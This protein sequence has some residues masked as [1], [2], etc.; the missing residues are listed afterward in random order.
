MGVFTNILRIAISAFFISTFATACSNG[1]CKLLDECSSDGDCEAG[2][3]CFSCAMEFSGSR[4]VRSTATD[5]FKLLNNSLPYNKYAYLTTHNAFA[6]D[7][8]P[9]HAGVPRITFNN[10]EDTITQQLNNGVRALMLDTYDFEDDIWLC[11]SAE[12]KCHHITAFEPA[13]D[14]LKEIEAFLAANPSEIVTLILEDYVKTP[15]GLTNVFTAAG[16]MKYWFPVS[17]MPRNG[18]DWPLVSDMVAN[19]QRLVVFT[20]RKSK[21][22][23]EGIAYQWDYMVENQYGQGGMKEGECPNRGESSPLN[24]K[25][26]SLVLV[27]YFGTIPI[28]Q[29]TCEQNSGDLINMLKTCYAAAGNRWANF[30]AVDFYKRSGGGGTFQVVDTLNGELL[31]GCDDVHACVAIWVI[32]SLQAFIMG[33]IYSIHQD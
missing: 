24:D 4:C 11:H 16:L 31:C 23:S 27:N 7:G 14:T 12:G 13:L 19:N 29:V 30:A 26:K 28:K 33:M 1:Q 15:N 32:R 25:T 5:Q 8:E 18:N 6:I 3:Y 9:S 2:L 20:S 17:K 22:Q 21:Q 10:Q